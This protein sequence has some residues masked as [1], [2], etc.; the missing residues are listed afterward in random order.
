MN[1][2]INIPGRQEHD[3]IYNPNTVIIHLEYTSVT[4]IV[5]YA[6]HNEN[7]KEG[8]DITYLYSA[9]GKEHKIKS[10]FKYINY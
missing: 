1:R 5:K 4:C 6:D 10:Q 2:A 3:T 7:V 9:E 8:I